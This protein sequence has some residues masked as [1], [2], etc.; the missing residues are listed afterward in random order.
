LEH[1]VLAS[2]W[3]LER[4]TVREIYERVGLPDGLVYTTIAKVVDRLV[5]KG[6]LKRKRA[7]KVFHYT[8]SVRRETVGRAEWKATLERL[9]GWDAAP[10]MATLVEAVEALDPALLDDLSKAVEARRKRRR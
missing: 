10:A 9:A 7:E 6:L 3:D 4:A 2:V 5:A 1:A 8:A